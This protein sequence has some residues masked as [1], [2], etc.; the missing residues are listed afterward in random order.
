MITVPG[1]PL[2]DLRLRVGSVLLR[3][4]V[5]A[6]LAE[7]AALHPEDHEHDPREAVWP[8]HD[9]RAHRAR[10]L[11][12]E[13]W[14]A[15]GSWSPT[16][17]TLT[18]VVQVAGRT[19][20]LQSLEGQGPAGRRTVDTGS[21]LVAEARGRGTGVAMRAA[22][23]SLAFDHLGARAA[24]TSARPRNVASLGVSRHLGYV[25]DPAP[26]PGD[27][28]ADLVHLR[29]DLTAWRA[30]ARPR[31]EVSGLEACRIFFGLDPAARPDD[32]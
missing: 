27:G 8:G 11:H 5:E 24:S 25:D 18:F 10:L 17:W 19:V 30:A 1:W 22:V 29:L 2:L 12:Q 14:R 4:A 6:D 31:V 15:M 9:R 28:P 13:Y 23:L 32:G 3:P 7:L 26:P 16:S 20:G 21:W